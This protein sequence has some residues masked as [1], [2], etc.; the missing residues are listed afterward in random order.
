LSADRILSARLP[1]SRQTHGLSSTLR[2]YRQQYGLSDPD[3]AAYLQ[4]PESK[5]DM[6][7]HSPQP[8]GGDYNRQLYE[9]AEAAD[10]NV[11]RLDAVLAD[12]A[13]RNE[14]SV[15]QPLPPPTEGP[16]MAVES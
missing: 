15:R 7:Y 13:R 12:V 3:L 8:N 10:C 5:L 16:H 2:G 6:L 4:M 14:Q 1:R 11:D 9:L